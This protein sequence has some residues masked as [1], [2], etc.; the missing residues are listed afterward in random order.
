MGNMKFGMY[1]KH[2]V[3]SS[4]ILGTCRYVLHLEC[5]RILRFTIRSC[6]IQKKSRWLIFHFKILKKSFLGP[7]YAAKGLYFIQNQIRS[8]SF[9]LLVF[10][11]SFESM[12][13]TS[14]FS[15]GKQK[16]YN[17]LNCKHSTTLVEM[18]NN[19]W[20]NFKRVI[21]P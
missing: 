12:E 11:D 13:H 15:S 10:E 16:S 17:Q 8:V 14:T 3:N 20:Q 2:V 9:V 6:H 18:W 4:Y 21:G 19:N 5:F 7:E 1:F